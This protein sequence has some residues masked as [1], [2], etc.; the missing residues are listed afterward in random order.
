MIKTASVVLLTL[1]LF[2]SCSS[3]GAMEYF[4]KNEHYERAMT[5]LQIGTLVDD[6]ETKAIL[7]VIYLNQVFDKEYQEG[8]N[9]YIATYIDNDPYDERQRG[10]KNKLYKLQLNDYNAT[11]VTELKYDD[12]LR[13]QMPLTERWSRYYYVRFDEI[14]S[15]DLSITFS[16]KK[17]GTIVL[18]F[19][20]DELEK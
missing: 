8:E 10:L 1:L 5:N 7:K 6:L 17:L 12:K 15:N 18:K 2:S 20:K 14:K 9:F 16:H 13:L 11:R 19:A 3:R 4:N